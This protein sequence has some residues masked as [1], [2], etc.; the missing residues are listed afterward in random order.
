MALSSA[1]SALTI[2]WGH[3]FK[4]LLWCLMMKFVMH[5]HRSSSRSPLWI[6]PSG[7]WCWRSPCPSSCWMSYLSFLPGTTWTLVNSWRSQPARAA[8]CLHAP[9]ASHGPLWP[10][11]CPWCCGSTALTLTCPPCCGPDWLQ[12][13]TLLVH[14]CEVDINTHT[15]NTVNINLEKLTVNTCTCSDGLS[16]V[17]SFVFRTFSPLCFWVWGSGLVIF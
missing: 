4:E 1:E 14:P 9:R 17:R 2:L 16:A 8:L 6:R 10:S 5:F 7:W 13:T 11:P 15:S 3:L 12:Y